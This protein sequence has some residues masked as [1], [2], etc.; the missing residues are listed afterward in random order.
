[1]GWMN[2]RLKNLF[3]LFP[4]KGIDALFVSSWPNVTYLSG[5]KGTESWALVSPKGL[6]FI[7]DSRYSEQAEKEARGFKV[8]LRDRRSVTEI[9]KDL[10]G[11]HRVRRLGFEAPIVT[12]SFYTALAKRVGKEKLK[13][14]AG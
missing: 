1:M 7:T 2:S 4:G 14:T 5:F 3:A 9:V 12:Y 13:A 11:K 8:I 6:Y 10:C